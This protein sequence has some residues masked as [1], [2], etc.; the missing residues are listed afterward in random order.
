MRASLKRKKQVRKYAAEHPGATIRE[1]QDALGI[2]S[3]SV[4]HRY[5]NTV[6]REDKIEMLREALM[7]CSSA[8]IAQK[9]SSCDGHSP[10]D[11]A[12]SRISAV[13]LISFLPS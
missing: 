13:V 3:P 10:P 2:S 7:A 5:L 4:V 12:A 8:C 1:I 11:F 6:T 9:H